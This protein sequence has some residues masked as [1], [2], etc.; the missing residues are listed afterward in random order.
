MNIHTRRDLFKFAP[1]AALAAT[2]TPALAYQAPVTETPDMPDWWRRITQAVKTGTDEDVGFELLFAYHKVMSDT[3]PDGSHVSSFFYQGNGHGGIDF[4]TIL[5]TA[6][7][8]NE[9]FWH[10]PAE[11]DGWFCGMGGVPGA[12]KREAV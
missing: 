1:A 6:R 4:D 10:R 2:A 12:A 11:F 8:D 3:A 7:R 9:M 5:M